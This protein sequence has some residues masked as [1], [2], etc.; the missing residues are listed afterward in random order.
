MVRTPFFTR[1]TKGCWEKP[2]ALTMFGISA[3]ILT[4]RFEMK[5]DKKSSNTFYAVEFIL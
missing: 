2:W 5:C 3:L 1:A 4:V